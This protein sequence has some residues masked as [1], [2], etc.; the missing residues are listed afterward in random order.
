MYTSRAPRHD[1]GA[2]SSDRHPSLGPWTSGAPAPGM[3]GGRN[4][5]NNAH[6]FHGAAGSGIGHGPS[7]TA[8]HNSRYGP[9]VAGDLFSHGYPPPPYAQ[10]PHQGFQQPTFPSVDP[11]RNNSFKRGHTSPYPNG[12]T[13][14]KQETVLGANEH[15]L[16]G[17]E[18]QFEN[19]V[20]HGR[21]S[22]QSAS[23][24]RTGR[25]TEQ[26]WRR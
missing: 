15:P 5:H 20:A 21:Q 14:I 1:H 25:K 13:R 7:R 17:G 24:K 16:V 9:H 18:G 2:Y 10:D 22:K 23:G 3:S 26:N 4:G 8:G 6:G 11:D 12:R 19:E